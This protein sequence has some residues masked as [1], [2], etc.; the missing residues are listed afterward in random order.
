LANYFVAV[1]YDFVRNHTLL[2][3]ERA[4]IAASI[5]FWVSLFMFSKLSGNLMAENHASC[6]K[7]LVFTPWFPEST[8]IF[9]RSAPRSPRRTQSSHHL[10]KEVQLTAAQ[11]TVAQLSTSPRGLL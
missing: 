8:N 3:I 2:Y 9:Y 7:F 4:K 1:E 11:L 10:H 6:R 5:L